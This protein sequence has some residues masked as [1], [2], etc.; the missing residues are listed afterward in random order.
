MHFHSKEALVAVPV[1][2]L[3]IPSHLCTRLQHTALSTG[4]HTAHPNRLYPSVYNTGLLY[5]EG[6][7]HQAPHPR[8][9]RPQVCIHFR[10]PQSRG[11]TSSLTYKKETKCSPTGIL[12]ISCPLN[13]TARCMAGKSLLLQP[14]L[15]HNHC[16]FAKLFSEP[17]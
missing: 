16:N 3:H 8:A 4:I 1:H 5:A 7:L 11:A 17:I 13:T 15:H 12:H 2:L 9:W 10:P 6:I 14:L